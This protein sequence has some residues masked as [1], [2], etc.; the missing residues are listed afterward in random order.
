MGARQYVAA[1][2]RFLEVDPV[3]G[4]VTNNYDYPSDPINMFDLSGESVGCK[5]IDGIACNGAGVRAAKHAHWVM[6]LG[7]TAREAMQKNKNAT[8]A[9]DSARAWGGVVEFLGKAEFVV[10]VVGSFGVASV[11]VAAVGGAT[12]VEGGVATVAIPFAEANLQH[13]FRARV[14][15]L[16]VDTVENRMLIQSA[17][18]AENYLRTT[19]QGA[20]IFQKLLSDGTE[21]WAHVHEGYIVNGGVNLI[22][23]G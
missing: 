18:S 19:P 12:L 3:E 4:G 21:A 1:L 16:V 22:P 11:P 7:Q 6:I 5:M 13:I 23:R 17:V 2:G 9:K 10:A 8:R 15:H 14:G 20:Q